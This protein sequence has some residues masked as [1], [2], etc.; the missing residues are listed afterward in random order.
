LTKSF[1]KDLTSL[2]NQKLPFKNWRFTKVDYK[3][4]F[5]F[6]EKD[7]KTY[8]WC[9]QHKYSSSETQGMYAIY[10]PNEHDA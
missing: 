9:E 2:S 5:N 7:G 3:A 10:K 6:S 1:A 4:E 8:Y